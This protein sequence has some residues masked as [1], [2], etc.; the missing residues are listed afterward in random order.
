MTDEPIVSTKE[1]PGLYDAFDTLKEGEEF[2]LLQAGD[3]LTPATILHWANAAR[4]ASRNESD[5]ALAKK[6]R[7]KANNAEEV[8]WRFEEYQ[9]DPETLARRAEEKRYDSEDLT[10]RN[11]ILARGCNRINNSIA[12]TLEFADKLQEMDEF[13]AERG[14]LREAVEILRAAGKRLEPRRH[15][16]DRKPTDG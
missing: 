7:D 11:V 16:Q 15:M 6:L 12:E 5:P 3:P 4:T 10:D 8:A 1:R 9:R 14:K 13:A 2:F